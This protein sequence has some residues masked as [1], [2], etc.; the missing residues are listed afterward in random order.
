MTLDYARALDGSKPLT[1]INGSTETNLYEVGNLPG[2][3]AWVVDARFPDRAALLPYESQTQNNGTYT[4]R[5]TA[6]G[7][8][9]GQFLVVPAGQENLPIE[10]SR[11]SVKPLKG[12]EYLAVGPSQFSAG[13]Q[14]LLARRSKEGLQAAFVDQEQLFDYYNSG[15]YGPVAI[16]NAVQATRPQYLLLVG[17]TTYDYHNYSGANVD[18]LCPAFLVSTT[19]WAQATSDSM[20]GDLGRGYPEVAVGRLPVNNATELSG[21]VSHILTYTGLTSSIRIQATADLTDPAAGN[22]AAESDSIAQANPDLA[23]QRNYYGQTVQ[24][25]PE[26]TGAMIAAA[27][28]GADILLYSGHGNAAHLGQAGETILDSTGVQQWT[29]N[30]ILLQ[31]TCAGNWM[32]NDVAGFKSLAMQALSQPQGGIS[33]SIGTSTY[34]SSQCATDFMSQLLAHAGTSRRWG[35]ALMNAQQWAHAQGGGFYADLSTT[36]QIF[37]DPAMPVFVQSAANNPQDSNTGTRTPQG[38][39]ALGRF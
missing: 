15:R 2:A 32:A 34:M 4:L 22:F 35:D 27:N 25:L 24:T 33:A 19:F 6:P 31:A 8:G 14:P 5:F 1:I 9:T 18:P 38:A 29:G 39:Q 37:G 30:V 17:R 21:A 23:W 11:R 7:G 3:N 10:V 13:V 20:F 12:N 28:G 36:E 16:Q 26:V